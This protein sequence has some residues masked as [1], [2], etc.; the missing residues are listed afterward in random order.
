MIF[1][2]GWD[3]P[4]YAHHFERCMI[5]INAIRALGFRSHFRVNRWI[6]DSGAFTQI[7]RRGRHGSLASY[8]Q[9]IWEFSRCGTLEAAVCQDYM[10][11]P[12]ALKATGLAVVDHQRMTTRRYRRLVEMLR[13]VGCPTY[14]MPVLQGWMPEDYARHTRQYGFEEGTWVGV[15]SVCKRNSTDPAE[16]RAIL[17]A[18][19]TERPDLRLHGFGLKATTLL[20][21]DTRRLLY[22]ADSMAWSYDRLHKRARAQ[23]N[24]NTFVDTRSARIK[25]A[26]DFAAR[27]AFPP[28]TRR[29]GGLRGD[30]APP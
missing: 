1:Y 23:R 2:V 30:D 6:L 14:V 11:E 4:S 8:A 16:V 18:I 12:A 5:S 25:Q 10:C 3:H 20:D 21:P 22:S 13:G 29:E 26:Q 17:E 15:G 28:A 9:R 7:T 19:L 24:G 27:F